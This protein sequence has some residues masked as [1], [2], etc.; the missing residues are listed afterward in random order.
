MLTG[1]LF[2]IGAGGSDGTPLDASN[3]PLEAL[4]A[5]LRARPAGSVKLEGGGSSG[6]LDE[7][8]PPNCDPLNEYDHELITHLLLQENDATV[9]AS[10]FRTFGVLTIAY[11]DLL[12][13]RPVAGVT[14]PDTRWLNDEARCRR[15]CLCVCAR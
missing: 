5:R 4:L 11:T 2:L 12:R 10:T 14:I 15:A 8:V 6:V 7:P 1:T 13:L 9:A 3:N